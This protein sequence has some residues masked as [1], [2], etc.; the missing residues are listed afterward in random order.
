[1]R[2]CLTCEALNLQPLPA[3]WLI[4]PA[5]LLLALSCLPSP[6]TTGI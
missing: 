1:M 5:W 3:T 2:G 6:L 4:L